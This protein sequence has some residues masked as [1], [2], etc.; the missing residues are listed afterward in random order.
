[1]IANFM[2]ITGETDEGRAVQVLA[3]CD[4]DLGQAVQL[5]FAAAEDGGS[6]AP[7]PPRAVS[8]PARRG[9]AGSDPRGG[10]HDRE[11][12]N[13]FRVTQRVTTLVD[14]DREAM[15]RD[16]ALIAQLMA[17]GGGIGGMGRAGGGRG[18]AGAPRRR[19]SDSDDDFGLGDDSDDGFGDDRRRPVGARPPPPPPAPPRRRDSDARPQQQ[20]VPGGPHALDRLFAPPIY[21]FPGD[22]KE[23]CASALAQSKWV[24][25]C[26]ADSD[27]LSC[28]LNRDVWA[29]D[30]VTQM[31]QAYAL[32]WVVQSTTPEGAA[33]IDGYKINTDAAGTLPYVA[34]L[35]PLTRAVEKSIPGRILVVHDHPSGR[36]AS[37]DR[38]VS[39]L[40]E[41]VELRGNYRHP[42][43][44]ARAPAAAPVA[45]APP[46][47]L[48]RTQSGGGLGTTTATTAP[49]P[50]PPTTT[51]APTDDDDLAAALRMS[52]D[53]NFAAQLKAIEEMEKKEEATRKANVA[54]TPA[55]PAPVV[56]VPAVAAPAAPVAAAPAAGEAALALIEGTHAQP[57]G[58]A[59]ALRLRVKLPDGAWDLSLSP[60]TPL[61]VFLDALRFRAKQPDGAQL[62]LRTG[63]PPKPLELPADAS[64]VVLGS[65]GLRSGDNV[66]PHFL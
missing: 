56:A 61:S 27:F 40:S 58:T 64:K 2:A 10:M 16:D 65:V 5:H 38:L 54:A 43:S 23:C 6:R 20:P 13:G 33:V 41:F 55:V 8:P 24:L 12:S 18:R 49:P 45:A 66:I 19:S 9:G 48:P 50:P 60:D 32:L 44:F 51:T 36:V 25:L 42:G 14:D 52:E 28:S 47:T 39:I 35:N 11:G 53:Q 46:A 37:A 31:V 63:F 1:M 22:L 26:V 21:A 59:G 29:N 17:R 15:T 30:V 7:Q 34:I 62:Q 4:F 3:S 57:V